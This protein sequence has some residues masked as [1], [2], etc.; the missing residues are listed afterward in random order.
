MV[1]VGIRTI[2]LDVEAESVDTITI[3]YLWLLRT[4]ILPKL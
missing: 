2:P 1:E 4:H 3:Y